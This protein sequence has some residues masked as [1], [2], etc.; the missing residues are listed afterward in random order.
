M[1]VG[2]HPDRVERTSRQTQFAEA[3]LVL[4]GRDGMGAVSFR[5]VAAEA[6]MSLGAVQKAFP[7]KES[8]LAAMFHLMREHAAGVRLA[9]PGT[10]DLSTWLLDLLIAILPLDQPRR[11]AQLQ[12]NTFAERA[13]YDPTIATVIAASDRQTADLLAL[14]VRRAQSTGEV[15]A[16]VDPDQ[17]AWAFLAVAQGLAARLLY[18]PAEEHDVR[19]RAGAAIDALLAHPSS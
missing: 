17:V 15:A 19:R 9:E 8:L 6:G 11:A 2:G 3:G 18:D 16:Q 13:A 7:N 1:S 4:L 14:L 5:T 10:P 12:A